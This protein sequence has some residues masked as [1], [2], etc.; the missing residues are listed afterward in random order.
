MQIAASAMVLPGRAIAETTWQGVALGADVSVTLRGD[1]AGAEATIGGTQRILRQMEAEFS[2][3]DLESSLSCLNR[4][5]RLTPSAEFRALINAAGYAH[6]LTG[7]LFDPTIQPLWQARAAGVE[8]GVARQSIGWDRLTIA[9]EVRLGE[10]QALTFNGIAQGYATDR[11][12]DFLA[13]RAFGPALINIGE[14]AALGGPFDV[15]IADPDFGLLGRRHLSN[16]AIATSSPFAM[17]LAGGS[18]IL[19]PK[20]ETPL[21]ST[22]SVE[23]DRATLADALST[24]LVFLDLTGIKAL[25]RAA[26][27]VR[28]VTLISF[29]GELST[30]SA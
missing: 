2:L 18:H 21:W 22:V 6:H 7:G 4:A 1:V 9:D 26:P 29:E 14:F 27:Q 15:G 17:R 30:I 5:E 20:G 3:F 24:A 16:T 23:A 8:E 25:I 13:T 10:G 28:S 11:V 19:G 12:C